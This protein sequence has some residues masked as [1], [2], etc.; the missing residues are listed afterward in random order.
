MVEIA[1][2]S[3]QSRTPTERLQTISQMM[4]NFVIPM[5]PQLQQRGIGVNMDEFM[6]IMAKYSNLPEMERILERIPQEQM[7]MMQQAGGA[8][9]RPL[10]SPVTSRTTIREN[11]AGATRQGNDQEAMRN[12]LAMANQG[13]QQ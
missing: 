10:Q 3:M 13:Q 2:Y 9:E 4:T 12:L 11:V 1:P 7:Q 5:A 8:G 6:Q